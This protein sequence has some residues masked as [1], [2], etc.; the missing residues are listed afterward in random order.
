M[1]LLAL[2]L[3]SNI[4]PE[5]NLVLAVSMLRGAGRIV[6]VS[7]AFETEP[8]GGPGQARFL[9]AALILET[10]ADAEAFKAQVVRGIERALGRVR[11][12]QDRDAARTIDIDVSFVIGGDAAAEDPDVARRAHVAVPL[13]EVAPDHV[14]ADGRTLAAIAAALAGGGAAP[15]PRPE[16]DLARAAGLAG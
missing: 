9:N 16:V 13:A 15:R 6:A 7:R 4:A 14:A 8:V 1:T 3:G 5:R 11:D 12:P 2:S 10:E